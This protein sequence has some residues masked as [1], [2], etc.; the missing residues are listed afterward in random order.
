MDLVF[1]ISDSHPVKILYLY[2][3]P[4]ILAMTTG[5]EP[6]Q[7]PTS[8]SRPFH[9]TGR[10]A[11]PSFTKMQ[12]AMAMVASQMFHCPLR[13]TYK[14]LYLEGKLLELL[15][16]EME[17]FDSPREKSLSYKPEEIR[18]LQQGRHILE[19]RVHNPPTLSQLARMVGLNEKKLKSGFRDLFGSTVYGYYQAQRMVKALSLFDDQYLGV[20]E[21]AMA[22]GYTNIS[23]FSA[24]FRKHFGIRPGDYLRTVRKRG[25]DSRP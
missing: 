21:A 17:H 3:T 12:P 19:E 6:Q 10:S 8:F 13:E 23:H 15:A 4:A 7:L 25:P 9:S 11:Y 20:S 1:E 24:A 2:L 16:L 18:R 5:L 14:G 22:V